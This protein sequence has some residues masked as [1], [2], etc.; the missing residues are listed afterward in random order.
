MATQRF[1]LNLCLFFPKIAKSEYYRLMAVRPSVRPHG[2]IQFP[3]ANF[4]EIRYLSIF[5]KKTEQNSK[6]IKFWREQGILYKN[7][8]IYIYHNIS[9]EFFL[10]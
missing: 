6:V 3:W 8:Y 7:I 9:L 5:R 10:E 4:H 2:I 1:S